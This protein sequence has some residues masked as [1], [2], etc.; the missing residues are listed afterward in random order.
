MSRAKE[1]L[2]SPRNKKK[3]LGTWSL[4]MRSRWERRV[5]E[6]LDNTPEVVSWSYERKKV[7][8]YNPVRKK[9]TFY[10]P[11]FWAKTKDGKEHILEVKPYKETH[12]PRRTKGKSER[13]WLYENATYQINQAKWAACQDYC[14]RIRADFQIVTEREIYRNKKER[15]LKG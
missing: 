6:Y 4:K 2:F 10:L 1:C 9:R 15:R 11:D 14:K 7:W 3:L 13:T 12:P 5:A 8:Y